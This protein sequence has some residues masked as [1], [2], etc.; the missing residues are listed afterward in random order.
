MF[1]VFFTTF[2][3]SFFN[4]FYV[5]ILRMKENDVL[6]VIKSALSD[7]SYIGDD[8]AYLKDLGLYVTQDTLVEGV[9][10]NLSY[11]TPYQLGI[12]AVTVN[13][14][15][16]FA[17]ICTPLYITV[18]LSLPKTTDIKFVDELYRGINFACCKYEVK[19]IGGDITGSDKVVISI[20]A[21]G[22]KR[23]KNEVSRSFA[24]EDN[25]I[26]ATGT[27]GAAS[28]GL[29]ALEHNIPAPKIITDAF[30]TPETRPLESWKIMGQINYD[31]AGTDSSDS[32]AETLFRVAESSG[33]SIKMHYNDIPVLPEVREFAKQNNIDEKDFVLWGG[34]D[35]ELIY[36]VEY[37][38]FSAMSTDLFSYI[39]MTV[40]KTD[41]PTITVYDN[42]NTIVID[43]TMIEQKSFNHFGG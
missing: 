3:N 1:K 23:L 14:S 37:W 30:L 32:L 15:D 38:S 19:V 7:S 28:A 4:N 31:V 12:K 18:S 2:Y 20:A 9:H 24:K 34:E 40:S 13:I 11:M 41:N 43:R 16:L 33:I 6:S 39:G 8:C 42:Q 35:Y 17:S 25:F 5:K 27:F 10:F 22:K 26:I 29:Y 36:F 21:I